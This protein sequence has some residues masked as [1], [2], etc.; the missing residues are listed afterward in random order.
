[1]FRI[2]DGFNYTRKGRRKKI[3]T[4]T[5]ISA[6]YYFTR[7]PLLIDLDNSEHMKITV[8]LN[9]A[10]HRG[11]DGYARKYKCTKNKAISSILK[12]VFH[13]D[14]PDLDFNY[15]VEKAEREKWRGV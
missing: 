15:T 10:I 14:K 1:M 5:D 2:L 8:Y 11:V 4:S 7:D 12:Q 9:P 13:I 3:I 6:G